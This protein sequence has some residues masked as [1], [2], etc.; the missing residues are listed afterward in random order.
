MAGEEVTTGKFMQ[1][2]VDCQGSVE[3]GEDEE[4]DITRPLF[5]FADAWLAVIENERVLFVVNLIPVCTPC[6]YTTS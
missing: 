3:F 6:W 4:S 1:P 5:A 2:N